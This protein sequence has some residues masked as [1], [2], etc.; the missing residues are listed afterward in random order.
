VSNPLKSILVVG[1]GTAGWLTAAVLAE[2]HNARLESGVQVTLIESPDV[3]TIGVG[4][5][6]WPSMRETLKRIGVSEIDF[7][8]ECSASF[9]QGSKFVGWRTGDDRE[10]YYHPF[11]L[12][13]GYL[14]ANLVPYWQAE[15][16][17]ISFASAFSSQE[18]LCQL[19]RAPKQPATPEYAAVANYAYHLD[20]GK[21]ATFLQRHCTEKLGVRHV[22]DHVTGVN[23]T[24]TGDIS[25]LSTRGHGPIEADL[26]VDCTGVASMLLGEHFGVPLLSQKDV[27]FNDRAI[28]MQVPYAKGNDTISS[29][30]IATARSSGW[31]WDIGLPSRRGVGYVY[32]SAHTNDEDAE[33]T[34]RNHVQSDPRSCRSTDIVAR[35]LRFNPGFRKEF[36]HR[37][38]VAVG[39]SAG[40]IEPLEASAIALVELSAAMIRD[41]LPANRQ[42]MTTVAG[43]FNQRFTYHWQRV[44]EFLKL[45][46]VLSSRTDSTYWRDH[47]RQES[48]PERLSDLLEL[49]Q[50]QP[51]SR[52]DFLQAEEIFPSAS[53]Q[54]M[55]YGMGFKTQQRSTS[56]P[57][58]SFELAAKYFEENRVQLDRQVGGLPSNRELIDHLARAAS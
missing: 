41:Q 39:M 14:Q 4:E 45:H 49:W 34:L 57:R 30:T 22:L 25:S 24:A 11:S 46:Y 1:G 55:L 50:F 40:F 27:L 17:D 38:C 36:W 28:A 48:I 10:F 37:N 35:K 19:G 9:K 32:S 20:A 53:Y 26:F 58:D 6:T 5:G 31:I 13:Q 51:P 2:G 43:R 7:I 16:P 15:H 44:I 29:A 42:V 8:R 56:S 18:A 21:F 23:S 33:V 52:H 3:A 47:G 12:P 54:Y